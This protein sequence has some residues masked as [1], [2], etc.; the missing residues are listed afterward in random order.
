MTNDILVFAEQRADAVHPA[1]LQCL[2]PA[3]DLAAKTGGKVVACVIGG[4]INN[5]ADA[6][7][8]AGAEQII[9]VSDPALEHY[10]PLRYRTALAQAIEKAQPRAILLAATFMGRDLGPRV[11]MRTGAGAATDCVEVALRD[12]GAVEVRRPLY[13][14]KAYAR[15]AFDKERSAVIS[16]RPNTFAAPSGGSGAQ[17]ESLAYEPASDDER[18]KVKD[19]AKT[20]G[21]VKDVTE[22]DIIVA[23]G[24]SLKNEE[25]FQMLYDLA[26]M[27]DAAVGA[28]R[29]ACDAGY[30]P[31]SRQVGLTGKTVT[32]KLYLA[33]GISGAIQHLAGMRGSKTIVAVNTDAEAPI[34]KVADYGLNADLFKVVPLL[35]EEVRQLK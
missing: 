20:G 14:G 3:K 31:H 8:Q 7:E 32:P 29:A 23:G 2:T 9:T 18:V 16:I 17:R 6:I 35:T 34:F 27:L 15:V 4:A 21:D 12:D 28:S 26:K 30:Q 13:N 10:S 22:A 5:A 11:A 1:A 33:F 24:R 25:N 19:V